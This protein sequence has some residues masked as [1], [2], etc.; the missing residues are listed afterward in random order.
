MEGT[1]SRVAQS[2]SS[3]GKL[4]KT[5]LW[6]WPIAAAGLL[7]VVGFFVRWQVEGQFRRHVANLLQTT[8]Q[9]DVAALQAWLASQ[10]ALAT[11][12]AS[13]ERNIQLIA[14]LQELAKRPEITLEQLAA[15]PEAK[16]LGQALE[17]WLDAYG[18]QGFG[19]IDPQGNV[20]AAK[21]RELVGK[22]DVQHQPEFF[23]SVFAGEAAVSRPERSRVM[24]QRPNGGQQVGLPTMFVA[25]PVR[26]EG[27][28]IAA[29]G[30]RIP[31][32]EAFTKILSVAQMGD[33]GETYAFDANG[34][35]L[36]Q[37]RF[38][39]QLKQI[40]LLVNLDHVRSILNVHI[41]DP[42]V[43]LVAGQRP[44][45]KP[46][47]QPLTRMAQSAVTGQS[48]VDAVG[49]RDYRGVPVV[50]AWCW[51]DKYGFG[52]TTEVDVAEAYAPLAPLKHVFW[53]LFALLVVSALAIWGF[54]LVVSRLQ[55]KVRREALKAE[56]LGQ[57]QLLDKI[58]EGGM[59]S[60]F[61]GR[62]A[63]LRRPTAV[64]LLD[65]EKTSPESIA[66]FEREVQLTSQL[67]HPNTIAIYDYGRT[68]EGLFYYAM[69]F[70]DGLTLDKLVRTDG[71][72]SEG[73]VIRI[74]SQVCGALAE[75]HASGLVHRDI[76]PANIMIN[77]RGGVPD[78]IKVLD[79]G[80][81]KA[82]DGRKQMDVT[83][84]GIMAGSPMY[85]SPEAIS[86][87]E[88]VD[89]RTDLYAVGAVSYFLLTG[90]R[91]FTGGSMMEIC[92]KQV[93]EQPVPPSVRL[94]RAIS[95]DLEALVL[96]CLEKDPALRPRRAQEIAERLL[97]CQEAG[98]W[99]ATQA[100]AWWHE[101]TVS[102][103]MEDPEVRST[104]GVDIKPTILQDQ[105]AT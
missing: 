51:L 99:S 68:P 79:F 31:P 29:L 53:G 57:Y 21:R 44:P 78:F 90:A 16:Q 94:G 41:R 25:A 7:V 15:A 43:N 22:G 47:D 1:Q 96:Q 13:D 88:H 34:L 10:E 20:L 86:T 76:K 87:P 104:I 39:D 72:Q 61:R 30:F 28:I 26:H 17:P 18:F 100:T 75:A 81:V 2:L 24:L 23:Q 74:M 56:Q 95:A 66:R 42:G 38:D 69:E 58:G 49:Y 92:M 62:H 89:A 98:E 5:E 103:P 32:E 84:T 67:N 52:V 33:S 83:S 46:A 45:Q 11:A 50:G 27:E 14:Q 85:M 55:G 3:T 102:T 91:L 37:S 93:G 97:A 12:C 80:L 9:A 101:K 64:K 48:E 35:L 73:R 36:S 70:L 4:L 65:P 82:V 60:V 19:V 6:I 71:P 59:G 105:P 63:L 40:G 54:T 77:C 8:L